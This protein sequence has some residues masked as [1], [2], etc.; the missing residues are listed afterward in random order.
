MVRDSIALP[1]RGVAVLVDA[2]SS[3]F[4]SVQA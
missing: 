4:Q 1:A 3:A 2:T